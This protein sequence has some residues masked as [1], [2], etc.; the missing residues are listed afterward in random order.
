MSAGDCQ[1]HQTELPES[2][3]VLGGAGW[4]M[5]GTRHVESPHLCL[6][7]SVGG[8]T[9]SYLL[10][11]DYLEQLPLHVCARVGRNISGRHL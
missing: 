3:R 10:W 2:V 4:A 1:A 8:L 9:L 11:L 6:E 7:V 5:L